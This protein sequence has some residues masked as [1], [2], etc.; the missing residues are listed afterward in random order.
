M[1][2]IAHPVF[3]LDGGPEEGNNCVA[4]SDAMLLDRSSGGRIRVSGSHVRAQTGDWSG[5]LTLDE[6]RYVDNADYGIPTSQDNSHD[7]ADLPRA[8]AHRGFILLI[9]YEVLVGTQFDCFKGNFSGNHAI[10]VNNRNPGGSW[11]ACDPGADGRAWKPHHPVPR[12]YMD[13]PDSLLRKAAGLLVTDFAGHRLGA[14]QA[15]VLFSTPDADV[16]TNPPD[17]IIPHVVLDG[18]VTSEVNVM[19]APA[20]GTTSTHQMALAKGQPCFSHPGG[21][22]VT[23]MSAAK[24]VPFVG[25]A[26]VG[27]NAVLIGT[28]VPYKDHAVR[29]TV[30]Y[31]PADAGPIS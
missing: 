24:A 6:V 20:W 18:P 27:W 22:K 8:S 25:H 30:L 12:G 17:H 7:W 2:L 15:Q 5:G 10:W 19:I 4:A 26:G 31:V 3:Q 28:A 14:G 29:P 11:H 1:V 16:V 13:Y 23:S 9:R 21:K